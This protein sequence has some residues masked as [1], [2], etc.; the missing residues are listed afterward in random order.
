MFSQAMSMMHAQQAQTVPHANAWPGHPNNFVHSNTG[1]VLNKLKAHLFGSQFLM[2]TPEAGINCFLDGESTCQDTTNE[3]QDRYSSACS[4]Q[5]TPHLQFESDWT[6][7]HSIADPKSAHTH[8]ESPSGMRSSHGDRGFPE[9]L[10]DQPPAPGSVA[11]S[12][13]F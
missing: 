12:M 3:R 7:A 1:T 13:S 9:T 10:V 6:S 4:L 8:I 5:S 2:L 11:I